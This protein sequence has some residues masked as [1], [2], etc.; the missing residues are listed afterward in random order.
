[1]GSLSSQNYLVGFLPALRNLFG[2]LFFQARWNYFHLQAGVIFSSKLLVGLIFSSKIFDG[3]PFSSKL[4]GGVSFS[5]TIIAVVSFSSKVLSGVP[6][7]STLLGSGSKIFG[8][9]PFSSC[10]LAPNYSVGILSIPS[11]LFGLFPD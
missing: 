1:M 11:Y 7:S 6:F 10:P 9:A 8:G 3:T 2:I 5:F 4:L